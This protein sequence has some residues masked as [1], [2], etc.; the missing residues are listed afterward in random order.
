M[1]ERFTDGARRAVVRAQEQARTLNHNYVGTEHLLLGLIGEGESGA[2]KAL[3]SMG[4]SLTAVR[5]QVEEI[6]GPGDGPAIDHVP[7]TP[8]A[9]KVLELA[10]RE[11]G[12]L[13]Y[14]NVGTEHILL[15]LVR[16]GDGV[17]A[18]VLVRLG[19]D[20]NRVRQRVIQQLH[21]FAGPVRVAV[22]GSRMGRR[23]R[24]QLPDDALARIDALADRLAAIERW[25]GMQPDL[26]QLDREIRKVRRDK[27]AAVGRQDFEAAAALRD[28]ENELTSSRAAR[29]TQWSQ[30]AAER[31]SLAGELGRVNA[32]LDRLR[33]ILREH[34]IDS[35]E[36]AA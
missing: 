10:H 32:E 35:G 21:G 14:H 8:R 4:I 13:G 25:V 33:A 23:V 5:Q 18:Q 9:K 28:Q 31:L 24:G 11:S 3:E 7:F 1:F 17:A 27:E 16:E 19:A 15:A 12:L 2:A 26:E 34:G 22:A 30:D 20:P 36:G 6:I 29:E